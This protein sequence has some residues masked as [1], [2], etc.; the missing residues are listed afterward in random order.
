MKII[1]EAIP[2]MAELSNIALST[3]FEMR[4]GTMDADEADIVI[5]L[6]MPLLMIQDASA[7]IR[8]I[9]EIGDQ[10]HGEK[11]HDLILSILW[12]VFAA[13]PFAGVATKA[14]GGAARIAQAALIIGEADNAALTIVEIV[15]DPTYAPFAILGL[16]LGAGGIKLKGPRSAFKDA[17]DIRRAMNGAAGIKL[18]SREFQR[19]ETS[20]QNIINACV[21]R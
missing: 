10:Q 14:L 9:E 20:V 12:I 18:F 7:S 5:S 16:L 11:T 1:D 13:I 3:Y 2:N 8:A 6:S 15:N 21:R 19:K 17:A 4:V